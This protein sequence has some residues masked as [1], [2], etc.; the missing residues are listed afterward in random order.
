MFLHPDY[1]EEEQDSAI[2]VLSKL[3][4]QNQSLKAELSKAQQFAMRLLLAKEIK[5]DENSVYFYDDAIIEYEEDWSKISDHF[6]VDFCNNSNRNMKDGL[7]LNH[8]QVRIKANTSFP[9]VGTSKEIYDRI[10][11]IE[12]QMNKP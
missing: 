9:P 8:I 11:Q 10:K 12:K 3:V 7:Y 1:T 4:Q 5:K 2:G 6:F